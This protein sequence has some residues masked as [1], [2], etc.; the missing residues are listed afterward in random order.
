M[1]VFTGAG[2]AMATPMNAD[3]SINF[4]A[5]EKMTDDQIAGGIDALIVCGTSGEAPT[6]EDDEHIEAISVVV[7]RAA[8]RVPVIGGTGS[9]NTA[10]ACMMSERARQ[11]GADAVLLVAPYYNK[12]TQEGLIK[13][14]TCIAEA[15]E[16]PCILYNVPSR[17]STNILPETAAYLGRHVENIVAIKEASGDISQ[18]ARCKEL[19]GDDLDI[20]SGNDDQTVPIMSLGGIGVISV[21]SNVAPRYTHD[22]AQAA[23]DG[24]FRKAAEMQ[25][26]CLELVRCLF[27][28]VNPIP[29]KAA[30]NMMG[31][32]AGIP[33]LPLT[34]MTQP[35]QKKLMKAMKELGCI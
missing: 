2:T 4:D 13:S 18:I 27:C 7:K 28:E 34:E 19:G 5:L 31:Y 35:N 6:L 25:L 20:Y 23:L 16:I 30:L 8:G 22:M 32:E 1:S 33:R 15:A 11:V 14:F 10:H 17:T 24:D 12:A 21:L 26:R 3:G 29:V 9:N